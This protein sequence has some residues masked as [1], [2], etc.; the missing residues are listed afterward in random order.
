M[1]SSRLLRPDAADDGRANPV[2]IGLHFVPG[3]AA[4]G[5]YE[6]HAAQGGQGRLRL[7]V[8]RRRLEGDAEL[9][10]P[11]IVEERESTT[12]IGPGARIQ[13]DESRNLSVQL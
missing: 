7:L 2:V 12:V 1:A 10:G 5:A 3:A 13:I 9:E 6:M 4:A 8:Q 11:A